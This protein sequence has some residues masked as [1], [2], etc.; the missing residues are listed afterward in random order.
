MN[1]TDPVSAGRHGTSLW[2][3]R[4]AAA[5]HSARSGHRVGRIGSAARQPCQEE[6]LWWGRRLHYSSVKHFFVLVFKPKAESVLLWIIDVWEYYLPYLYSG[7]SLCG[8]LLLLCKYIGILITAATEHISDVCQ[9]PSVF[10]LSVHSLWVVPN[11]QRDWEPT[12]Q[13]TGVLRSP[14]FAFKYMFCECSVSVTVS[15]VFTLIFLVTF[16]C[17]RMWKKVWV[18]PC[19]RKTTSQGNWTVS[20]L[21][22]LCWCPVLGWYFQFEDEWFCVIIAGTTSCW[23]KMNMETMQ[24]EYQRVHNKR[25]SL[26]KIGWRSSTCRVSVNVHRIVVIFLSASSQKCGGRHHHGSETWATHW[27]CWCSSRWRYWLLYEFLWS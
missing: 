15:V 11:V 13:T 24:K 5:S 16:S 26:G 10:S 17:W 2:G 12:G 14:A 22:S 6:S 1:S 25:I 7:I 3:R 23:V 4:F 20:I 21:L 27:P 9:Q 19:L 8:V 18:A